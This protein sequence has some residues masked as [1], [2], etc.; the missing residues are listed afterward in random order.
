MTQ[1]PK[2]LILL[3]H[4]GLLPSKANAALAAAAASLPNVEVVDMYALY[5]TGTVDADA[6]VARL[7]AAERIVLQF[8]IHWY[9]PPPLLQAWQNAVLTRMFYILYEAE[10]RRLEGTPLMVAATAGNTPEAYEPDGQN[11]FPLAELLRPLQAMANRCGL[12]W[13]EPFLTYR[14]DK[15]DETELA[16]AAEA[17]A[18]RLRTWAS[19]KTQR[20]A[21]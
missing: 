10:G 3:F 11:L 4:P 8:P 15:L 1:S 19:R 14:A 21:A 13:A 16:A 20:A 12:P 6:E 18:T 9:A 2:S 7:L 17:Y 5:P